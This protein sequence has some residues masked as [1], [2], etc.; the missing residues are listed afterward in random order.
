MFKVLAALRE[1]V[2]TLLKGAATLTMVASFLAT[3]VCQVLK[4]IKVVN[5]VAATLLFAIL[6]FVLPKIKVANE[7]T[8]T[9]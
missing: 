9:L 6:I 4:K 2:T 8:A 3:F 5:E 1:A 7:V